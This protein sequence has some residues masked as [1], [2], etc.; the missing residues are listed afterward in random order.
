MLENAT[1]SDDQGAVVGDATVYE[2]V[3]RLSLQL[4]AV[5][6]NEFLTQYALAASNELGADYFLIG[7]LNPTSNIVRTVRLVD[8]AKVAPNFRYSLD[9]TPCAYA[10]KGETCFFADDVAKTFPY[11]K[12]LLKMGVKGYVG[13]PL[14]SASGDTQGII[15]ALTKSPMENEPLAREIIEHFRARVACA[16]E[17]CETLERYAFV[18]ADTAEGVWD[19][20]VAIGSAAMSPGIFKA[21]GYS[22]DFHDLSQL[23]NLFHPDDKNAHVEAVKNHMNRGA[24]Y[25]LKVRL[26]ARHGAYKWF[27]S[28]GRAIRDEDGHL[29]RMIG[30]ISDIDDLMA[31]TKSA[32]AGD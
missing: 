27:R 7:K 13:T 14:K 31:E 24:P 8:G 20:D 1:F 5:A 12:L 17:I 28:R 4:A 26:R 3:G 25:D 15:V 16:L 9:G 32:V 10:A 19:W 6:E 18:L 29:V 22:E 21:L 11:D 23:D 2:A 30:R